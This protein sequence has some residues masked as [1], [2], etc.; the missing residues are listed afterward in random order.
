METKVIVIVSAIATTAAISASFGAGYWLSGTLHDNESLRAA[1][2][3]AVANKLADDKLRDTLAAKDKKHFEELSNARIEND[4]LRLDL[5]AGT[6][7]VRV[8]V[9]NCKATTTAS[10]DDAAGT[11][12]LL[13]AD[14]E[15]IFRITGEADRAAIQLTALQNWAIAVTGSTAKGGDP[16]S[17]AHE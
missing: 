9:S 16:L 15:N 17:H 4:K 5:A 12:E 3:A 8:A 2:D 6:K 7:R 10:V 13:P 14:A 1:N 11:A